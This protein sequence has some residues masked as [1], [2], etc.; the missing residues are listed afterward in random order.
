M[1]AKEYA[2]WT[3][4]HA[5]LFW[6]NSPADTALFKAW[7]PLITPYDLADFLEASNHLATE[8]ASAFRT[9]HFGIMRRRVEQKRNKRIRAEYERRSEDAQGSLCSICGHGRGV[10]HVPHQRFIFDGRWIPP[11]PTCAQYCSCRLG[12]VKFDKHYQNAQQNDKPCPMSWES[13]VCKVPDW[14][15][16]LLERERQRQDE[17]DASNL[18]AHVDRQTPLR[19][20]LAKILTQRVEKKRDVPH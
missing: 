9:E 3:D 19:G 14:A 4:H 5:A 6:M 13:Y 10:L 11:Y 2:I 1:I 8:Q 20:D 15:E 18:A 16:I 17:D 12:R 7:M